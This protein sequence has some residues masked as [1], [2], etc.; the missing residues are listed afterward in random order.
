MVDPTIIFDGGALMIRFGLIHIIVIVGSLVVAFGVVRILDVILTKCLPEKGRLADNAGKCELAL[1]ILILLGIPVA[2][3]TMGNTIWVIDD[4]P[5][6]NLEH[7]RYFLLSDQ[8]TA[9][10]LDG[11]T[12]AVAKT[13]DAIEYVVNATSGVIFVETVQYGGSPYFEPHTKEQLKPGA[14]YGTWIVNQVGPPPEKMAVYQKDGYG[15]AF[16]TFV[17]R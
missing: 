7:R 17:H 14:V 5:G 16:L 9:E 3:G 10:R 1:F 4:G 2:V 8:G 12:I 6:G 11:T 13:P 15:C